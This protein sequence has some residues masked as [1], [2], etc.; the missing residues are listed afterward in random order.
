MTPISRR[1]LL[2]ALAVA[3]LA[4]CTVDPVTPPQ[5]SSPSSSSASPTPTAWPS[6]PGDPQSV[7]AAV[8]DGA[9]GVS[10][11]VLAGD[12]LK[13]TYPDVTTRL[14]RTQKVA[15][16]LAGRFT[17]GNTPPDLLDNSGPDPLPIA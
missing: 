10:Y 5:P 9:F 11:V 12:A 14:I 1:T 3:P 15:T 7:T 17:D 6:R 2:S 4:A 8:F 16:E 13:K